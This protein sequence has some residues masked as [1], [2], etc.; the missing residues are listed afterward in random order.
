MGGDY[1]LFIML[2]KIKKHWT[3]SL[4]GFLSGIFLIFSPTLFDFMQFVPNFAIS[5]SGIFFKSSGFEELVLFAL[6]YL[7]LS[8]PIFFIYLVIMYSLKIRNLSFIISSFVF[9]LIGVVLAEASFLILAIASISQWHP[10]I[11]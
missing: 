3:I 2:E 7:L 4:L 5:F 6:P 10:Q 8:L 1:S 11:L 9:F